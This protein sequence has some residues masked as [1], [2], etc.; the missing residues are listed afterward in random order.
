[1]NDVVIVKVDDWEGLYVNGVLEEEQHQIRICDLKAHLPI[2]H[3][4]EIYLNETG[5]DEIQNYVGCFPQK[6]SDMPSTW[7]DREDN[8]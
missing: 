4:K 1:M 3:I 6:F 7:F 5:E 2:A 8:C